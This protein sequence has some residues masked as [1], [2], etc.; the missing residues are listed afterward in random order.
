MANKTEM[1]DLIDA[2]ESALKRRGI[3]A[4][5]A[6]KEAVGN[7]SAIKNLQGLLERGPGERANALH[8]LIKIAEFLGLEL[9]LDPPQPPKAETVRSNHETIALLDE[10]AFVDRFDIALSAGPGT[11]GEN[12]RELAPVA[13]RRDWMMERGL[14]AEKC[15]VCSVRGN[16]MEPMLFEGDL[17][18]LD[19]RQSDLRDGQIYGVV[20]IEGDTRIKRVELIDNGLLLRSENSDCPTELRLGEDANRVQIIGSLAWSGHSYSAF[21]Q[22]PVR[23][24]PRR[25][26]MKHEW[27]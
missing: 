24:T 26:R 18:L 2:I 16:S 7:P 12:A 27:I 9:H 10:F 6:S 23:Q 11:G 5:A 3:S 14:I 13:F 20:D 25:R 22:S 19:R 4:A 21:R 17:V 1:A 15:V 8:N